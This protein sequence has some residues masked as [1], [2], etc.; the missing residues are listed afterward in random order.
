MMRRLVMPAGAVVALVALWVGPAAAQG[1]FGDEETRLVREAAERESAGDLDGAEAALRHLLE[2]DPV[3]TG[4]IYGLERILRAKGELQELLPLVD[5]FL[6]HRDDSGVRSLMLQLLVETGSPEGMEVEAQ[7]WMTRSPRDETVYVEVARA[8]EMAYGP[9]RALEVLEQG[10]EQIGPD[11]LAVAMGDY[12]AARGDLNGAV[13][14]WVKAVSADESNVQMVRRRIEALSEGETEAGRRLVG[15]L[16]DSPLDRHRRVATRLAIELHL[17]AEALELARRE[18]DAL[19]GRARSQYLEEIS[20]AATAAGASQ[21]ASWAYGEL[22]RSEANPAD[23]RMLEQRRAEA[24]LESGDTL[25]A[26]AAFDRAAATMTVGSTEWR[27]VEARALRIAAAANQIDRMRTYWDSFRAASPGGPDLD[28]LGAV[29]AS[30]LVAWGDVQ[31]AVTVLDQ[32]EGPRSTLERAYLLL[33]GGEISAGSGAL[34]AAVPGLPAADATEVIQLASLL[35]RVSPE[36]ATALATAGVQAHLGRGA[37]GAATLADKAFGLP[38][39]DQPL[40]LAEAARMAD[41]AGED[42]AAADIRKRLVEENP[43]APEVGEASLALARH[44]ARVEGNTAEAIRILEDLIVRQPNA[45]VVPE[46]RTEL[47]RLRS[48][49]S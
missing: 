45:A 11:A 32:V 23:R 35:G 30:T 46:A 27:V 47:E 2:I 16:G 13:D 6:S 39:A 26:L 36:A 8:Y 37:A 24:S 34:M 20:V 22:G 19:T 14:E 28:A 4:G 12:R 43:D 18:A 25:A 9:E 49:G 15:A 38:A 42:D 48:S 10:R 21:V 33:A 17:G 1:R 3:S 31:G 40:L 7:R 41:R 44:L 29:T 5:A